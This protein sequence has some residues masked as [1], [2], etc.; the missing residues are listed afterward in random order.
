[1]STSKR[2]ADRR[3]ADMSADVSTCQPVRILVGYEKTGRNVS[4]CADRHVSGHHESFHRVTQVLTLLTGLLRNILDLYIYNYLKSLESID[5]LSRTFEQKRI[6]CQQDVFCSSSTR[7]STS[8]IM[9]AGVSAHVSRTGNLAESLTASADICELSI[10]K[11][12]A[13]NAN[14]ERSLP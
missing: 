9:S 14:D 6:F 2:P 4:A 11:N 1:M 7:A 13:N 5:S 10:C 3:P 12:N 8:I